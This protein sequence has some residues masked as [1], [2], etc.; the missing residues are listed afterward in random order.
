MDVSGPLAHDAMPPTD[1]P[2]SARFQ[3]RVQ[4]AGQ[5]IQVVHNETA[6]AKNGLWGREGERV[7]KGGDGWELMRFDGG[8]AALDFVIVGGGWGLG[9]RVLGKGWPGEVKHVEKTC[10]TVLG[11]V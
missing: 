5:R 7:G 4:T 10:F 11:G 3:P 9:K 2:M 8:A 1:T 6:G